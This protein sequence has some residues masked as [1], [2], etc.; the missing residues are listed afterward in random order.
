VQV[1]VVAEEAA[2]LTTTLTPTPLPGCLPDDLNEVFTLLYLAE[3]DPCALVS[4]VE[5]AGQAIPLSALSVPQVFAECAIDA[6]LIPTWV[7]LM[8]RLSLLNPDLWTAVDAINASDP[9]CAFARAI[10]SQQRLPDDMRG[11]SDQ[12]GVELLALACLPAIDGARL[13]QLL[14]NIATLGPIDWRAESACAT[15]QAASDLGAM[16]AIDSLLIDHI[17]LLGCPNRRDL[18]AHWAQFQTYYGYSEEQIA[19]I[20]CNPVEWPEGRGFVIEDYPPE[21]QTWLGEAI[22]MT[23]DRCALPN[24]RAFEVITTLLQY[25]PDLSAPYGATTLWYALLLSADPCQALEDYIKFGI[26]PPAIAAAPAAT[27]LP[28]VAISQPEPPPVP[29]PQPQQVEAAAAAV[30]SAPV[31]E[32]A[33]ALGP[34]V[35]CGPATAIYMAALADGAHEVRVLHRGAERV[36]DRRWFLDSLMMQTDAIITFPAIDRTGDRVIYLVTLGDTVWLYRTQLNDQNDATDSEPHQL[37]A[38]EDLDDTGLEGYRLG[39]YA[40]VM[41]P[42]GS[43]ALITIEDGD[44]LPSIYRL[45]LGQNPELDTEPISVR[46]GGLAPAYS[47]EGEETYITYVRVD[48]PGQ[49]EGEIAIRATRS[50]V[51][52]VIPQTIGQRCFSP[53]FDTSVEALAVFYLCRENGSVVFYRW[54]QSDNESRPATID[55]QGIDLANINR[56]AS[57]PATG[58]LAFDD[59]RRIYFGQFEVAEDG[60]ATLGPRVLLEDAAIRLSAL[61]WAAPSSED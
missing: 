32:P 61:R 29:Q 37:L 50:D 2:E 22:E 58:Y 43:E 3:E 21:Q 42:D 4:I 28:P 36:L 48:A 5:A 60:S 53:A 59:G 31:D 9:E 27:P 45:L 33:C 34:E 13:E 10:V 47:V 7:D 6:A 15:V 30:I 26:L 14:T 25:W 1:I 16:D 51:T 54:S 55:V 8:G 18:I 39:R 57:G 12:A 24:L 44:G 20:T 17:T 35:I 41:H 46:G 52:A 11:L 23:T 40:P 49:T 38:D 19:Q 56:I